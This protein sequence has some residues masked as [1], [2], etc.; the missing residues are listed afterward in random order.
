[1]NLFQR[2]TQKIFDIT[3]YWMRIRIFGLD[4]DEKLFLDVA[5][6]GERKIDDYYKSGFTLKINKRECNEIKATMKFVLSRYHGRYY[7]NFLEELSS[8][9]S[10]FH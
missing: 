10:N 2:I 1:M 5:R 8:F 6:E 7:Q 9:E 4:E 3:P